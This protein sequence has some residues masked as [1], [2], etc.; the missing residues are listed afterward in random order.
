VGLA[1]KEGPVLRLMLGPALLY[2]ALGGVL[3]A[4]LVYL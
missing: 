1:G 4:L 3:V 2:A